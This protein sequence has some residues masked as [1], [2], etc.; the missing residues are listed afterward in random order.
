MAATPSWTPEEVW[1]NLQFVDGRVFCAFNEIIR[2]LRT[3]LPAAIDYANAQLGY[4][5][6]SGILK[7]RGYYVAPTS[8][9]T[10]SY[11]NTVIVGGESTTEV[12]H[13]GDFKNV[14]QVV[15]YS[16]HERF[17]IA[18][19]YADSLDRSGLIRGILLRY[20]TGCVDPQ[21]RPVWRQL[22]PTGVSPLPERYAT[23]SGVA[24]RYTMVQTP[25]FN[26]WI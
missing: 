5:E 2:R 10:D 24:M 11:I 26:N 18:E 6:D 19:Q 4:D 12:Q 20:L 23:Y 17:E 1:A 3:E 21:D 25:N 13:P 22:E 8:E 9:L 14:T 15:V 16:I 7:P